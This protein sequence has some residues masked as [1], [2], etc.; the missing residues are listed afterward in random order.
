MKTLILVALA[1]LFAHLPLPMIAADSAPA[2]ARYPLACGKTL[3]L[4]VHVQI[5]P[6][7]KNPDRW[8]LAM[9]RWNDRYPDTFRE[10]T[11]SPD[12]TIAR[13]DLFMWV[14][15]G[16]CLGGPTIVYA[17]DFPE[18]YPEHEMGH[19]LGWPDHI[20]RD[21]YDPAGYIG[22]GFCPEDGY[23]GL[24]SYCRKPAGTFGPSDDEMMHGIGR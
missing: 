12:V 13:A 15:M 17:A 21:L 2:P 1:L 4:P 3:P 18:P 19:T 23:D 24:M 6:Q 8:R 14:R 7:V 5:L 20:Q 11:S 9:Q 16:M 10:V 22:P